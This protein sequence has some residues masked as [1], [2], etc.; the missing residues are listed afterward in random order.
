MDEPTIPEI[1]RGSFSALPDPP[2]FR[3]KWPDDSKEQE[4]C[5]QLLV[6]MVGNEALPFPDR[7]WAYETLE[8]IAREDIYGWGLQGSARD[9]IREFSVAV[10][11]GEVTR[12][13]RSRG[14]RQADNRLRNVLVVRAVAWLVFDMGYVETDAIETVREALPRAGGGKLTSQRIRDVIAVAGPIEKYRNQIEAF[15]SV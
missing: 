12:P 6:D 7:A 14:R 13:R 8:A 15:D 11:A 3:L 4:R 2:Y 9:A 10:L 1:L 5:I